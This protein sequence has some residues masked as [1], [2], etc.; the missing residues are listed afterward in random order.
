MA[1][2]ES[3]PLRRGLGALF[4]EG[5]RRLVI[6]DFWFA[7]FFSIEFGVRRRVDLPDHSVNPDVVIRSSH[8]A[9]VVHH[10]KAAIQI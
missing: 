6:G 10:P 9:N 2:R 5:L 8:Q 1:R 4:Q 7:S 3:S